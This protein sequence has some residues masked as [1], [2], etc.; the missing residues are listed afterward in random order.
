MAIWNRHKKHINSELPEIDPNNTEEQEVQVLTE[1]QIPVEELGESDE[2]RTSD[3]VIEN[4]ISD[5][6]IPEWTLGGPKKEVE[7]EFVV[8]SENEE[9]TEIEEEQQTQETTPVEKMVSSSASEVNVTTEVIDT[10]TSEGTVP[11]SISFVTTASEE[12]ATLSLDDEGLTVGEEEATLSLGDEG[13]TAGEEEATLSLGDEGLT[14][15]EEEATLSLGDE[16]LTAGEEEATLSLDDEGLTVGEEEATLSLG[17]EGL[18]AGEEEATLSLGD[19]GLTVGAEE[20]TLSI[21]D[22]DTP[23][24]IEK[25]EIVTEAEHTPVSEPELSLDDI[26]I[27]TIQEPAIE[28]TPSSNEVISENDVSS[29]EIMI[30][31]E[32]PEFTLSANSKSPDII[33]ELTTEEKSEEKSVTPSIEPEVEIS[34]D[35]FSSKDDDDEVNLL[36]SLKELDANVSD[37]QLNSL[38]D[39]LE[40]SE[41]IR[42][43]SVSAQEDMADVIQRDETEKEL[44]S[45]KPAEDIVLEEESPV[46]SI[47]EPVVEEPVVE[48]ISEP[49]VEAIP[50]PVIEEPVVESI[51][52]PVID[53]PVV[54]V[55]PEPVIDEPVIDE[56][57]V[58]DIVGENFEAEESESSMPKYEKIE[59]DEMEPLSI[60][61]EDTDDG[62]ISEYDT[63]PT[64]S[65][66]E[67][68][69]SEPATE[70]V[71]STT[72]EETESGFAYSL[73]DVAAS[74]EIE[75]ED[76][77][78]ESRMKFEEVIRQ[79]EDGE[80]RYFKLLF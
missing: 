24:V 3:V 9:K 36:S 12:E 61:L 10:P 50:E 26:D 16:G 79:T 33:D 76:D 5:E 68:K 64:V 1:E 11:E 57:V 14:V 54:E 28:E 71:E 25:P 49:V 18:T 20:V 59:F 55:I 47:P 78:I 27:P 6:F 23:V 56:P 41:S 51:P 42:R 62:T 67:K 60:P 58:E 19:E 40:M 63:V 2:G 29:D 69:Q 80:R 35:D 66:L 44:E 32:L 46:E 75:D 53:E 31:E 43:M 45:A 48:A 38:L 34:L 22:I 39:R 4:P 52:E 70:E 73:D 7:Q 72:S 13:L 17:D 77:E 21:D 74:V 8:S 15:G 30:E 37:E 65:N